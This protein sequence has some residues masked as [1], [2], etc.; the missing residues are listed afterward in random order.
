LEGYYELNCICH[1]VFIVCSG[2]TQREALEDGKKIQR[3]DPEVKR[4]EFVEIFYTQTWFLARCFRLTYAFVSSENP[5]NAMKEGTLNLGRE[6]G[7]FVATI[8]VSSISMTV[9]LGKS[10]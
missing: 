3:P 10:N 9:C 5:V 7:F 1:F 8:A 6:V 4:Y 2:R